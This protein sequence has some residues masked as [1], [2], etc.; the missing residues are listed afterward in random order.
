MLSR[1][2]GRRLIVQDAVVADAIWGRGWEEVAAAVACN[3][4]VLDGAGVR[5]GVRRQRA[6]VARRRR[7]CAKSCGARSERLTFS[8]RSDNDLEL[9]VHFSFPGN[10][11]NKPRRLG[12]RATRFRAPDDSRRCAAARRHHRVPATIDNPC[13]PDPVV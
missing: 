6:A 1:R 2:G 13:H 12:N 8:W 9:N 10:R 3:R 7:C 11:K 5:W 4:E